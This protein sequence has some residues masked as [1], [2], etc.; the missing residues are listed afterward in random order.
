MPLIERA[1]PDPVRQ[2]RSAAWLDGFGNQRPMLLLAITE[3]E[4][5]RDRWR[6]GSGGSRCRNAGRALARVDREALLQVA[7]YRLVT[8]AGAALEALAGAVR[9]CRQRRY[10]E[11]DYRLGMA[12]QSLAQA[13]NVARAQAGR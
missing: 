2:A 7:D 8:A 6:S 9:A 12:R 13:R 3:L 5:E 10:F 4:R 11:L 1:L